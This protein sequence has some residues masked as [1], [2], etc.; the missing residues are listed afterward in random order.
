MA[1]RRGEPLLKTSHIGLPFWVCLCHYQR[2][3]GTSPKIMCVI[4]VQGPRLLHISIPLIAF[5]WLECSLLFWVG[6][7]CLPSLSLYCV[8]TA[9]PVEVVCLN[10]IMKFH[11]PV[12]K[13]A[14]AHFFL[15]NGTYCLSMNFIISLFCS[16]KGD[17]AIFP[18]KHPLLK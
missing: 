2:S 10:V 4:K 9:T 8:K 3:D 14:T 6:C 1:E 5:C 7:D 18:F 16:W 11:M 13:N 12:Y 17:G 15:K